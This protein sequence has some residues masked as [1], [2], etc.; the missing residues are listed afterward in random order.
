MHRFSVMRRHPRNTRPMSNLASS[1]P[2]TTAEDRHRFELGYMCLTGVF[3]ASLVAC[4]LIFQK[5]F[6]LS[7]PLPWGEPYEFQQSVGLLA[8]P[9][10][11]LVTD[12]LSE[13]YGKRRA[14]NVVTA[15]FIASVFVVGLVEVA[16]RT[17][18]AG[19][20]IDDAMFHH[21]FG[22]SKVAV[23]S[24]MLAYLTAQYVDIRLFHFWKRLTKG[25]HLWLRNNASTIAS[26]LLDTV[27]V[28][29][30]LAAFGASGI[31]W[32]RLGALILNGLLFK[33]LFALVDTPLFYL[34][35]FWFRRRFPTLVD[36]ADDA[37][38]A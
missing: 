23:F 32:D 2:A 29:V 24:S 5:F 14:S 12:V 7:F 4:N 35:T 10:T 37:P 28:L 27:V 36:R 38:A 34:A 15:G 25:R 33:W 20:G 30:L 16:D 19:F 26:Q 22:L 17:S 18:S 13:V 11:F 21:V 31:T 6:R 8:Y 9:F 3:L 1:T